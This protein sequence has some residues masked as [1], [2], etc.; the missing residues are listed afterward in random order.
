MVLSKVGGGEKMICKQCNTQFPKFQVIDNKRRHLGNRKYCLSCSP[1]NLHNT[2]TFGY[3]TVQN[4]ERSCTICNKPYKAKGVMCG[5]CQSN[6]KRYERKLM[7]IK[8]LGGSC[9]NCGYKK[10]PAALVFHHT[11][12]AN[13]SFEISVSYGRS[14]EKVKAELKKCI[15]LC[16]NC[17]AEKHWDEN[18]EGREIYKAN[19]IKAKIKRKTL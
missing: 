3:I 10:C 15:L 9:T 7:A 1:F 16:Q 19:I 14:F 11:D 2:K 5:T 13:K 6:Y 4:Q 8:L 12:P 18:E 17:H